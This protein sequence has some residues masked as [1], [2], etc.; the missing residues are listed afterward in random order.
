LTPAGEVVIASPDENPDLYWGL[1]GGGGNF[2]IVTTFE[3]KLHPFGP[4]ILNVDLA[5]TPDAG[6]EALRA[7]FAVAE[8]GPMPSSPVPPS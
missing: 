7:L 1:R 4:N 6:A 5:F 3:F 2:G 8:D